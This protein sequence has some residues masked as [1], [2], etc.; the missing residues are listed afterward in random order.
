MNLGSYYNKANLQIKDSLLLLMSHKPFKQISITEITRQ[1]NVNRSTF[2][3]YYNNKESLLFEIEEDMI[4]GL[5]KSFKAPYDHNKQKN[6]AKV[7]HSTIVIFNYILENQDFFTLIV[8]SKYLGRFQRKMINEIV[9][10]LENDLLFVTQPNK[11]HI[12]HKQYI[13][14]KA[15]GIYGLIFEWIKN[16]YK[17]TPAHMSDQLVKI[18][19]SH[20][21]AIYKR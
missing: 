3:R 6:L 10:L 13:Y 14:F 9:D 7:S 15:Y 2:Y 21:I 5:R 8:Q 16:G 12:D 19:N 1:A 20:S 11:D 18:F 17:D 4:S